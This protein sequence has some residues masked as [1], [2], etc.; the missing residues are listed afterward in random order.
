MKG[1]TR[2][3][4]RNHARKAAIRRISRFAAGQPP[5]PERKER[6]LPHKKGRERD[7][8]RYWD[9]TSDPYDVNVV[10]YR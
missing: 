7:G 3:F 6:T 4:R 10:L 8:G 1:L 2:I 5:V 9:R